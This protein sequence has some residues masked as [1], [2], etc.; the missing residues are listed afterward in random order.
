MNQT[1][2]AKDEQLEQEMLAFSSRQEAI[3]A[4]VSDVII[5]EKA[6]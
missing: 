4:V 3:L 5:M 6:E 1:E 2:R